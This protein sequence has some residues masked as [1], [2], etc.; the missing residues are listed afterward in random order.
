LTVVEAVEAELAKSPAA[1]SAMAATALALARELD[2]PG[3][4]A[5]SKSMC[6]KALVDVLRELRA[7]APPAEEE[8]EL[9]RRRREREQRLAGLSTARPAPPS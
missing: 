8:T 9:D 6:A 7:L 5:T 4:S 3:N 1:N 2:A